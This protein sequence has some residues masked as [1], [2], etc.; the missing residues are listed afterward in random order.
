MIDLA[1]D[2]SSLLTA[3]LYATVAWS[4]LHTFQFGFHIATLNGISDVVV[5]QGG[6][7]PGDRHFMAKEKTR[8]AS[9]CISMTVGHLK[10]VSDASIA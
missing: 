6:G 1:T 5:C 8:W 10:L 9:E 3:K 2:S 4:A 7:N